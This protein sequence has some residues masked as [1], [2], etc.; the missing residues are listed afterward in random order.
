M[1]K[2]IMFASIIIV[3]F[4]ALNVIGLKADSNYDLNMNSNNYIY[5]QYDNIEKL[6]KEINNDNDIDS[7]LVKVEKDKDYTIN[8]FADFIL[9]VIVNK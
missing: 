7:I 4:I 3:L 8:Y 5:N 9:E 2:I 6:E 1:K